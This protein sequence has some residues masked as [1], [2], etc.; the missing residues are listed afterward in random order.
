MRIGIGANLGALTGADAFS[1]SGAGVLAGAGRIALRNCPRSAIAEIMAG[2]FACTRFDRCTLRPMREVSP[3]ADSVPSTRLATAWAPRAAIAPPASVA[4]ALA[5]IATSGANIFGSPFWKLAWRSA[6]VLN[7][8]SHI[9]HGASKG[10]EMADLRKD[11]IEAWFGCLPDDVRS[12]LPDGTDGDV[13]AAMAVTE[14]LKGLSSPED[15]LSFVAFNQDSFLSMGRA[16]RVRFLA[17]LAKRTYP[18]KIGVIDVLTDE[19]GDG[20]GVMG[21]VAP[22][23]LEDIRAIVEALGPRAAK[24]IVDADTIAV[25]AGA[26]YELKSEMDMRQGGAI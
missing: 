6:T 3:P 13:E 17:W 24:G 1:R 5:P 25:I 22:V 8:H 2:P 11:S 10:Q 21:K 23:F 18:E 26:G 7:V 4:S 15:I 9:M 20:Q 12:A 16:R 14:G 19:N